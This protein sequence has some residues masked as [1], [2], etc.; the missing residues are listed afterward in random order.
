MISIQSN[1]DSLIAQSNLNLD[2]QFQSNIIQ[3]FTSGLPD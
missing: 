2:D 3:Q 1:V